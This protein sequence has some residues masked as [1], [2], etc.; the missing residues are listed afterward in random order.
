MGL[1][2]EKIH[3]GGTRTPATPAALPVRSLMCVAPACVD[4][5]G[6]PQR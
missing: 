4:T 1:K 3:R 5:F 6:V 2:N